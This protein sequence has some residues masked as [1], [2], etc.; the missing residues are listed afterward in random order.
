MGKCVYL[1]PG[2]HVHLGKIVVGEKAVGL[3]PIFGGARCNSMCTLDVI[4]PSLLLVERDV[5]LWQKHFLMVR[6]VVGSILHG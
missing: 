6:W 1:R 2:C 3:F 4:R 5:A